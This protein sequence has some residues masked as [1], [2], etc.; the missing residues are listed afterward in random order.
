MGALG[1]PLAWHRHHVALEQHGFYTAP[2]RIASFILPLRC[3]VGS[4][5]GVRIPFTWYK[6][7]DS[8][9]MVPEAPIERKLCSQLVSACIPS[10]ACIRASEWAARDPHSAS[11][12][13]LY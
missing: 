10:L 8:F 3:R 5:H 4:G 9:P 13:L 6:H 1:I 2:P 7:P 11:M 12:A